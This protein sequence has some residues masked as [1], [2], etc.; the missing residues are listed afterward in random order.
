MLTALA[1]DFR[2]TARF[3]SGTGAYR[4]ISSGALQLHDRNTLDGQN[5]VLVVKGTARY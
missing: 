1:G 2:G 5:G 4:G 3:T